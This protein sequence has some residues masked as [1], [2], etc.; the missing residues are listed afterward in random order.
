MARAAWTAMMLR[1]SALRGSRLG[2]DRRSAAGRAEDVERAADGIPAGRVRARLGLN[3]L[4]L[5]EALAVEAH[6][7]AGLADRHVEALDVGVEHHDVGD[8]GQGQAFDRVAAV[9]VEDDERAA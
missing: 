7:D 5:L 2:I 3:G 9:A 6:D 1:A 4:D 8:A